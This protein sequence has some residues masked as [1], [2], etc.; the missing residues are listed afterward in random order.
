MEK[1]I[2]SRDWD[3]FCFEVDLDLRKKNEN[4]RHALYDAFHFC[5]KHEWK[6]KGFNQVKFCIQCLYHKY[7]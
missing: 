4:D 7:I 6:V 2:I 3:D 1:S 5:L